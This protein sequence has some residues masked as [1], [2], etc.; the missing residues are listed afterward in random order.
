MSTRVPFI[1]RE[2]EL[3]IIEE[4]IE[5]YGERRVIYVRA[6]GGIGKT[7]LLQEVGNRRG[8]I[9]ARSLL[10]PEIID[11][12]ENTIYHEMNFALRIADLLGVQYFKDFFQELRDLT[13][14]QSLGVSRGQLERR[15]AEVDQGFVK[16]FQKITSQQRV[17]LRLDTIEKAPRALNYIL[18][19]TT[20]IDNVVL[21]MAGRPEPEA[22]DELVRSKLEGK[23]HIIPLTALNEKASEV[24]LE[25]KQELLHT[26]LSPEL[27]EKLLYLARGK[28]IFIDLAIEWLT[29]GR[30]IPWFLEKSLKELK[31][32]SN[33]ELMQF[34]SQLVN[35]IADTRTLLDR[36]V[37]VLAHCY[38]L[39]LSMIEELLMISPSDAKALKNEAEGYVF[40]KALP[41]ERITLHDEMRRMVETHV[42]PIV[43]PD[44]ERQ[45][46]INKAASDYL[47]KRIKQITKGLQTQASSPPLEM[48]QWR[49]TQAKKEELWTLK[50][51]L[52]RH[53]LM[54]DFSKGLKRF[55][56]MFSEATD[57]Y[58]YPLRLNWVELVEEQEDKLLPTKRFEVMIRKAK[59]LLDDAQYSKAEK[60]L[61]DA[62]NLSLKPEQEV[63]L[64][65][66][67]A[68]V[69]IRQGRLRDGI[70]LFSK[71]VDI[72]KRQNLRKWLAKA[73]NGLGWAYRLTAQFR[74][75]RE[76]YEEALKVAI[77]DNL[78]KE[79]ALLY[80][81]LGF[82][83]AY[84]KDLPRCNERAVQFCKEALRLSQER[85]DQRGMGRAY[86]ALGSVNFIAGNI[87]Q[88]M[89]YFQKALDIFEP[90]GDEEW[91]S[92]VYA[93]R[94]AAYM[95]KPYKD[96]ELAKK[97]LLRAEAFDIAK[98]KPMILSRLSLIY[99]LEGN[100]NKAEGVAQACREKSLEL[101]DIW[102]QWVSI[103]DI[104]RVARYQKAYHRF[105]EV[106]T[107]MNAYLN[108]WPDPD[109]RAWGMLLLE[110][111]SLALGKGNISTAVDYYDDGM[112]ILTKLG[113]YGGDTPEVYLERLE[114]NVFKD[115]LALLPT[116]IRE[117]GTQLL[118]NWQ[119]ED[120][121]ILYPGLRKFYV[122]WS[123]WED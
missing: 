72:S 77:A 123:Q 52:L 120:L 44:E 67:Q 17:V 16:A 9:E 80:N 13:E 42:W 57:S 34:E 32:L 95:S 1:N 113:R 4:S 78:L 103:R 85:G 21:L 28:P 121:H 70:D 49:K 48:T 115:T 30:P 2:E 71:A 116:Q 110:L 108:R 92:Q 55:F 107:M 97:D 10:M 87:V 40:I 36:L 18:E 76:H 27:A 37:L 56:E 81:N 6:E 41:G 54:I 117:I 63:D 51:Q 14:I 114:Q 29:R 118:T 88:A 50:E 79:Q 15:R 11:F 109:K 62:Q 64:L 105:E 75:A 101:P 74:E 112:R 8:H 111:G 61:L 93:W 68:N 83:Y 12:D 58:R 66:Q 84:E 73:E 86:S 38:P 59:A 39:D 23:I 94:G 3:D 5:T 104:A 25:E 119:K 47:K 98:D 7:R 31:L 43:D 26:G 122:R 100:L 53:L 35:H 90:A 89:Q 99:L 65:I 96:F 22:A 91:L 33:E 60:I 46:R 82:L 19:A 20:S 69:V 102:Y 45:Q 24:Y 106:K